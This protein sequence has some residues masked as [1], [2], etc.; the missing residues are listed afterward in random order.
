MLIVK[1]Q[2]I[3]LRHWIKKRGCV[4]VCKIHSATSTADGPNLSLVECTTSFEANQCSELRS[5]N[6][7]PPGSF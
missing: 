5:L 4:L 6:T 7:C 1:C 2:R 3:D